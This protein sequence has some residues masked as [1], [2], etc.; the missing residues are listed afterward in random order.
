MPLAPLAPLALLALLALLAPSAQAPADFSGRWIVA[1]PPDPATKG[2]P[3]ARGDMGSGWGATIAITQDTKQLVVES[4]VYTRYDLQPQ[5]RFVYALDGSE[6]RN[7]LTLGRGPQVQTSRAGWDGSSL[8]I[9]TTHHFNDPASGKPLALELTQKLSLLSE[10]RLVIEATR[11]GVLGG[12][13]STTKTS[14]I[15]WLEPKP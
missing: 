14:Y 1:A 15:R 4:I 7:T 8:T 2:Q 6:T 9:T 3:P 11:S 5:P 10:G 12:P 13:P